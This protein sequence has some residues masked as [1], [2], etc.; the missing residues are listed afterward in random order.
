L[1]NFGFGLSYTEFE[2]S[3][4]EVSA[5]SPAGEFSVSFKIKNK[6]EVRGR[7]IAQVYISDPES[8]LPRAVKELQGFTKVDLQP[9]E[10]KIA[11]VLLDK[12]ALSFYNDQQSNWVAEKGIFCVLVSA[13][14]V[15]VKLKGEA[16]LE[17]TFSWKGL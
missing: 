9:G 10:T 8:S 16:K 15:D 2:Y 3:D 5:I 17:K 7:E 1:F 13:S 6:G 4:L 12:H 11:K 14:L